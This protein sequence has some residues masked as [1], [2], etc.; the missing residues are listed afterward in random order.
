MRDRVAFSNNAK[1]LYLKLQ[2]FADARLHSSLKNLQLN[3][4]CTI[5]IFL[6]IPRTPLKGYILEHL[7]VTASTKI[8]LLIPGLHEKVIH[9]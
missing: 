8:N 4:D 6:R 9:T 2:S 7:W 5:D 3:K 1:H